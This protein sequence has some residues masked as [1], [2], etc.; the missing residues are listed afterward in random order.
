MK[1]RTET[2]WRALFAEHDEGNLSASAFCKA[3]GLCP[4]Y[5]S[6]RRKQLLGA[7][8]SKVVSAFVAVKPKRSVTEL[9]DVRLRVDAAELHFTSAAPSFIAAVVKQ[10]R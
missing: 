3:K 4:K 1:K 6:L 8:D 7:N 5:F 9:G 2:Q 10:L